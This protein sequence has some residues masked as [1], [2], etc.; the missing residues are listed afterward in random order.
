MG[1]EWGGGGFFTRKQ[2]GRQ[3]AIILQRRRDPTSGNDLPVD[4]SPQR[5]ATL[6]SLPVLL[7]QELLD[8]RGELTDESPP[9]SPGSAVTSTVSTVWTC[10]TA[11]FELNPECLPI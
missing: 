4:R 10:S 3:G 6:K 1:E 2:T 9:T 11:T 7:I 5:G 8:V